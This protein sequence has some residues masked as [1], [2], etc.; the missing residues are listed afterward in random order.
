M[1]IVESLLS[2]VRKKTPLVHFITNYVTVND[3]ANIT[4]A[5]G[6]SPIMADEISEI[7]Q[8]SNQCAA[9]VINIGTVNERTLEAMLRAG[10]YANKLG[11]PVVLDPV[12]AG[13]SDFRSNAVHLLLREV[14][15]S[16]I[17][18]NISEIKFV[19]DGI[20]SI[21]GV[22]A[23][24]ADLVNEAS[25]VETLMFSKQLS[26]ITGSVIVI[27]GPIDIV[28]NHQTGYAVRN[29]H[30]M[31]TSISGT[32]CMSGAALGCF[33]GANPSYQFEAAVASTVAM[34]ICG[35]LANEKLMT[36]DAGVSTY[37]NLLIDCMGKLSG[38]QLN[39]HIK[40]Q[41]L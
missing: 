33:I 15:F 29:G 10:K 3:C 14:N 1:E 32:G 23:S 8:I 16:V 6:G 30:H 35:E 4:L 12:G 27:T 20:V 19:S 18:G 26:I 28:A 36:I 5:C 17:K 25:V 21:Q 37:R 41:Q 40:I 31:M 24:P 22:D 2:N 39:K 9:L 38:D 34:G 11:I 7:E 13:A